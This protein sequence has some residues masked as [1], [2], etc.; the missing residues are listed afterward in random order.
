MDILKEFLEST[1]IHGLYYISTCKSWFAK[2]GWMVVVALGFASSTFLIH[3]S[4][5]DWAASPVATTITPHSV[6]DL[7]FP[8]VTICP[9]KGLNG[10]LKYDLMR[11][12]KKNISLGKKEELLD[13]TARV[14]QNAGVKAIVD[15]IGE[16]NIESLYS[17]F[18][19]ITQDK[20][21]I[22]I[23]MS[24]LNGTFESP[25]YGKKVTAQIRQQLVGAR[26]KFKLELET[27]KSLMGEEG[28]LNLQLHVDPGVELKVSS[29]SNQLP[30][31][32]LHICSKVS[33][34]YQFFRERLSWDEAQDS[35]MR[36]G[37]NLA[38]IL[39]KDDQQELID[40]TQG[41]SSSFWI[42]GRK[43]TN[44][45]SSF[46]W[47]DGSPWTNYTNFEPYYQPY[48]AYR[49]LNI[50]REWWYVSRCSYSKYFVCQFHQ[51]DT[52]QHQ[53]QLS[54][55]ILSNSI[56]FFMDVSNDSLGS[57]IVPGFKVV[58]IIFKI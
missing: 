11:L 20:E 43:L 12:A 57:M 52:S 16:R 30:L 15:L 54:K 35:C 50:Y 27:I 21:N 17:G 33:G 48:Y 32:F 26:V 10:A 36:K 51:L 42:G 25:Y 40:A 39:S 19:V 9:P 18:Q 56:D 44:D 49:C 22:L 47:R 1:T 4:F 14:F 29:S 2:A 6:A 7:P 13:M 41:Y 38:S 58:Q 46:S 45:E 34:K 5:A 55:N 37:G 24:N 28:K 31:V 8:N 3:S 53:F 23:T